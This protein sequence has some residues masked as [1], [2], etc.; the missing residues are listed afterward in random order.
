[1]KVFPASILGLLV[2]GIFGWIGVLT[3]QSIHST[4]QK[5]LRPLTIH[6]T[7]AEIEDKSRDMA[8]YCRDAARLLYEHGTGSK[9]EI[10]KMV[11]LQEMDHMFTQIE[12]ECIHIRNKEERN[13]K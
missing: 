8:W 4:P 12:S 7:V 2:G 1:M 9:D 5:S 10:K 3:V 13:G 11:W 6:Y